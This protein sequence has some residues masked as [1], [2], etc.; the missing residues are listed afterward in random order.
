MKRRAVH[1]TRLLAAISLPFV[2]TENCT[3]WGLAGS[4]LRSTLLT[5]SAAWSGGSDARM[6]DEDVAEARPGPGRLEG[7]VVETLRGEPPDDPR[8][9]RD[10]AVDRDLSSGRS[11]YSPR[12]PVAH[13]LDPYDR[14]HATASR[15]RWSP[16][17]LATPAP[18]LAVELDQPEHVV[19]RPPAR[20]ERAEQPQGL[21]DRQ[22]VVQLRFLEVNAEPRPQ[23]AVVAA[24]RPTSSCGRRRTRAGFPAGAVGWGTVRIQAWHVTRGAPT[25]TCR[26]Q[27]SGRSGSG[28]A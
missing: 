15:C 16:D 5:S 7:G 27:A 28:R 1:R 3:P 21:D 4:C 17:S 26:R 11:P 14:A 23:R 19:D 2:A 25:A 13:K 12:P 22:L 20:V 10:G 24:V 9:D 6:G 18:A 8:V